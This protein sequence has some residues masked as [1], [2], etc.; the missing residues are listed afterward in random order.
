[1]RYFGLISLL[2]VVLIIS[3]WAVRSLSSSNPA[4]TAADQTQAEAAAKALYLQKKSTGMD[5]SNGPC[6]SDEVI[7]NWAVDTVHNPREVIDDF[8][9]NQCQSVL[10]GKVKHFIELDLDGNF[11]RAQ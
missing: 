4:K 9:G 11:V 3:W 6:L 10:D 2:I 7:N 8:S 5:F 1:M